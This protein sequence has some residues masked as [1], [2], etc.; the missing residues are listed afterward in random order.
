MNDGGLLGGLLSD[1]DTLLILAV[2]Y[3]L[4]RQDADKTLIL[5]LLSILIG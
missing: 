3:I 4:Y 2:C 5:A 1:S